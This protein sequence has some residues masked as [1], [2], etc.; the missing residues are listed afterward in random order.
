MS[1]NNDNYWRANLKL[2]AWCLLVW[3]CLSFL[4]GIV[5]VEELNQ[6]RLGGYRLGFWFA[7]QGSIFS[8]LI[9]IIFYNWRIHKLDQQ[10]RNRAGGDQ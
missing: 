4:C 8:F 2:I 7:Q 10:Y 6:F 5:F 3:F 1:P 9:L